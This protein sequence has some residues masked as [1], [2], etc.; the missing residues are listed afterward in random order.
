M[1]KAKN[2]I[3]KKIEKMW[4]QAQEGISKLNKDVSKLMKKSEKNLTS[5]YKNVKNKT[6]EVIIKAKRE[7]LYYELGR[8]ITPYLTPGQINNKKISKIYLKIRQLKKELRS[9]R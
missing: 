4:P 3:Q 5:L 6:A 8:A 2:I 9:T 1:K 7:E